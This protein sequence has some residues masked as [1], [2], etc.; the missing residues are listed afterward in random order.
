MMNNNYLTP[1]QFLSIVIVNAMMLMPMSYRLS[2]LEHSH[3]EVITEQVRY[4]A[5]VVYETNIEEPKSEPTEALEPIPEPMY[6]VSYVLTD[7]EIDLIALLTMG[8]AEGETEEGK[9][10]VID[11][12]LNRVDSEHFPDT[13]KDVIYQP[14]QYT[15][16]WNTRVDRCYV[17]ED[18]RQLVIE[19]SIE[20]TNTEVV[21]FRT[22]YYHPFGTPLFQVGN[23]YFSKY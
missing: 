15:A 1:K 8:E 11:S 17:R 19:E 23:H 22:E 14:S 20:R 9:R 7:E 13:V 18:I 5:P 4:E 16:M 12:V 2:E 6:E 21:F 10:L 3:A